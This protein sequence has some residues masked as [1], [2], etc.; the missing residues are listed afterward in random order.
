[1][2]GIACVTLPESAAELAETLGQRVENESVGICVFTKAGPRDGMHRAVTTAIEDSVGLEDLDAVVAL[3]LLQQTEHLVD[4]AA[5]CLALLVDGDHQKAAV[6]KIARGSDRN[7]VRG[8]A[9]EKF[10]HGAEH[11]FAPSL[12]ERG[13]DAEDP[14]A[15]VVGKLGNVESS[16]SDYTPEVSF[17]K[18][19]QRFKSQER[20]QEDSRPL[21]AAAIL[22]EIAYADGEFTPAEDGDLVGYLKRAFSLTDEMAQELITAADELRARTIDHFGLTNY[23]RRSTPLADRIELVKTMWRMVYS[24]RKLTDYENYLVR[25]LADLL[26]IEHHVMIEAKV[27][28]LRELGMATA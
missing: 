8:P 24:D 2:P 22:L 27:A 6:Q 28:V 21:A 23:L 15:C 3:E 10:V 9:I 25:K 11:R 5:G 17:A 14:D 16:H 20:P 13:R 1:M 19:M 12:I 7:L 18:L 4:R 26:G